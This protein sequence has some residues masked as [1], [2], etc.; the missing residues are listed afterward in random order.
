MSFKISYHALATLKSY[1]LGYCCYLNKEMLLP[2]YKIEDFISHCADSIK[3]QIGATHR[4]VCIWFI[5]R[6]S[7]CFWAT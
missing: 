7:R 5:W 1:P 3:V 6:W 4:G 2:V